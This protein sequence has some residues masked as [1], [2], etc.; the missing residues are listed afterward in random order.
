MGR[1]YIKKQQNKF[2]A[3]GGATMWEGPCCEINN[4]KTNSMLLEELQCGKGH[5]VK[6]N[7]KTNSMLWEELQCGP[8]CCEK[9]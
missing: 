3:F 5:P 9:H 4:N 2:H 8:P 7:N 1:V 6:N